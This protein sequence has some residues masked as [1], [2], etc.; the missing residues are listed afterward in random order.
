M[1]FTEQENDAYFWVEFIGKNDMTIQ[2]DPKYE[3]SYILRLI[4]KTIDDENEKRNQI[5]NQNK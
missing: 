3:W 2:K 5:K 4:A 1:E